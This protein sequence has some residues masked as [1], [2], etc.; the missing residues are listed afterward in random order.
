MFQAVLSASPLL[1]QSQLQW[2]AQ[3]VCVEQG[4]QCVDL[5]Q[6]AAAVL[7]ERPEPE[8][9]V[10]LI[11]DKVG[12]SRTSLAHKHFLPTLSNTQI[13]SSVPSKINVQRKTM[14]TLCVEE[15]WGESCIT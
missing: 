1:S 14:H 4:K 9:H 12:F 15:D 6:T 13:N 8:G 2:F 3:G 5:L 11:L 7:A 10:V